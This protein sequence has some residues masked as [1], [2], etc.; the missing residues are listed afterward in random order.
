MTTADRNAGFAARFVGGLADGGVTEAFV[1]PG[2][3]H[4][5]LILAAAIEPRITDRNV[6][7]ER[8]AGFMALGYA[9]RTGIPAVVMCTSG[10]AAAQYL[11]SI[12]EADR[13]STPLLVVTADRPVRL[14]GTAAPQT[15]DQVELYGRHVKRFFDADD[16][17]DGRKLAHEAVSQ[18]VNGTPGP[19]HVNV[20][21]DEPLVP[22]SGP[23]PSDP[24]PMP[25]IEGRIDPD[26]GSFPS[27]TD[28][29]VIIVAGGRQ[30]PGFGPALEHLARTIDAPIFADPQASVRGSAVIHRSDLL[31]QTQAG[32]YHVLDTNS[33]D[34]VIR[35]GALPTSKPLW[36]WLASCGVEQ[37][38]VDDGRYGDPLASASLH[39]DMDPTTYLEAMSRLPTPGRA[40]SYTDRW[41]HLDAVATEAM[42]DAIDSLEFPNEPA[43][44]RI[45]GAEAPQGS[46]LYVASSRP[47]RDVDTF[48]DRRDDLVVLANRGVNGIDGTISSA[49]GAALGGSP[50]TLLLGD[51]ALLHDATA[52]GE[53]A[54]LDVPLRI[55]VVNN[56]GGGIFS[57]LPQGSSPYI[58]TALY[59]RH[60]GTPHGLPLS[61][62]AR[63]FGV[64]AWRID[65]RS[66][67]V[68]AVASPIR[69]PELIEVETD[70]TRLVSD[71]RF[72]ADAV[73][74][75][76]RRSD[77]VEERT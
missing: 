16:A 31:A 15:M 42:T 23:V 76:L 26:P 57:F 29:S 58:D 36:Q 50:T 46:T 44:T 73:A 32:G 45:V 64:N 72:I 10:S 38:L 71:H 1:S 28:R 67:L 8:S 18:A 9:K 43:V 77:Q 47:I 12:V 6:R 37:V 20:A 7:D 48:T 53:A 21:F 52:L 34:L 54:A 70:R 49:I 56:D 41:K 5:P 61:G 17:S 11:P 40:R 68:D 59:E 60:W 75:A 19:V 55:V 66:S 65:D 2:S 13:S 30:R 33:P 69:G 22:D 74:D 27:F 35:L 39:L 14:R 24:A 51:I 63:A 62:I 4:T 25:A 3:R